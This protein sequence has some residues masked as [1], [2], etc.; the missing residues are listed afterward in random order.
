ML[1]HKEQ[2]IHSEWLYMQQQQLPAKESTKRNPTWTYCDERFWPCRKILSGHRH[3]EKTGG[4]AGLR[5][6]GKSAVCLAWTVLSLVSLFHKII[7]VNAF[8]LKE[9]VVQTRFRSIVFAHMVKGNL[10]K[11]HSEDSKVQLKITKITFCCNYM[12]AKHIH[13]SAHK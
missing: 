1:Y 9:W 11:L 8:N 5:P 3:D 13:D 2:H 7:W 4:K 12:N 10:K 6:V